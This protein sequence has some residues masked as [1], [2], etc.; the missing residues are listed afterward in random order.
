MAAAVVGSCSSS[1]RLFRR[2]AAEDIG[3]AAE[4]RAAGTLLGGGAVEVEGV[5]S[6]P[7]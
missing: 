2:E 7:E 1:N 4:V 5:D 6:K 3:G